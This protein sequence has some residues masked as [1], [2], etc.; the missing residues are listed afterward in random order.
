V[1]DVTFT[2]GD[3]LSGKV[4]EDISLYGVDI[5]R[6]MNDGSLTGTLKLDQTGKNNADLVNAA[7]AGRCFV[8]AERDGLPFWGGIVGSSTY[9]AQSKSLQIYARALESYPD[10][11]FITTDFDETGEQ[12]QIFLDLYTLMQNDPNSIKVGLPTYSGPV[13]VSKHV[14]AKA[15]ELKTY[16]SLIDNLADADDG[17]DWT[18]DWTRQGG[19]YIR[20]L[21]F[22]YPFLGSTRASALNFEYPG[23]IT[24][25]WLTGAIGGAGTHIFGL[26]AGEGDAMLRSTFVHDLL[27][28]GGAPRYDVMVSHKEITHQEVLDGI[29]NQEAAIRKI[30]AL[31]ITIE[32][33]G[34]QEPVFG[35]YNV[36]DAATLWFNDPMHPELTSWTSRIVGWDYKPPS[37]N[38]TEY[39]KVTFEGDDLG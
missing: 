31:S 5:N 20:T 26:G 22:G 10:R 9:Q 13:L 7:V 11:R 18:I 38:S 21:R 34:T 24:N 33:S 30:P 3:A 39:V 14:T 35:S 8:V 15:S 32:L 16:R 12:L 29:I 36:G 6:T 23:N 19:A 1:P 27:L 4:I 25:Y 28:A 2:F 17:F 37:S